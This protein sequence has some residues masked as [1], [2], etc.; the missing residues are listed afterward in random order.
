VR[1]REIRGLSIIIV[2][3]SGVASVNTVENIANFGK[4]RIRASREECRR[5]RSANLRI[6]AY[7]RG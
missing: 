4:V 2:I 5:V 6:L 7:A 3:V 1:S